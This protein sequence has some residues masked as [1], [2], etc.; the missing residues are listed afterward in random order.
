[1]AENGITEQPEGGQSPGQ[2]G[3]SAKWWII[4]GGG[5]GGGVLLVIIVA[6]VLLFVTGVIGGGLPQ[7]ASSLDLVPDDAHRVFTADVQ[8]I[9][10]SDYLADEFDLDDLDEVDDLG[11]HPN[12]L[13]EIV[14]AASY[15]GDIIILKGDFN[16]G[17]VRDEFEDQ[18]GE[19]EPYRGYE[20]WED[21]YGGG[22]AALLD[23][24][25]VA[26]DSVR[27]VENT[28]KNLYNGDGSLARTSEGNEMKRILDKLGRGF[29]VQVVAGNMCDVD[30]CEGYGY[31]ITDVDDRAE[32][33]KIEIA[34]LFGNE[35]T[36]ERAAD[37]YDEI[38][39]FLEHREDIDIEDTKS[40]G[41]FVVGVA[42]QELY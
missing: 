34:F 28:L 42:Y 26:S 24:Y 5:A 21:L 22:A 17:D 19:Q 25:I 33:A 12:D 4:I 13:S 14:F 23:G 29:A 9:L 36:A 6:V 32:E 11:L 40:E 8:K 16:L 30:R 39:N 27:A 37:D 38:A 2:S 35:R 31:V 1:M 3:I 18:D 20:V 7:P 10:D 15:D 41:R